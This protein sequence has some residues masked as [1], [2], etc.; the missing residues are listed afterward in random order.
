MLT[1]QQLEERAE[2]ALSLAARMRDAE[3]RQAMIETARR[4]EFLAVRAAE[5]ERAEQQN[6]SRLLRAQG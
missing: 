1:A 6:K 2:E 4:Y 5:R 3:G